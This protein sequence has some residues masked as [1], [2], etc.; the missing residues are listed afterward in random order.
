MID[1]KGTQ[2]GSKIVSDDSR[3]TFTFAVKLALKNSPKF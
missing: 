2:V 1:A 3:Y